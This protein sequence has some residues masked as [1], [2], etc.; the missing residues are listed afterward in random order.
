MWGTPSLRGGTLLVGNR[1]A[2]GSERVRPEHASAA[3]VA[4]VATRSRAGDPASIVLL[5][6]ALA[7]ARDADEAGSRAADLIRE[8]LRVDA[9]VRIAQPDSAGRL[10][11]IWRDGAGGPGAPGSRVA[12]RT[13]Y[14]H[15]VATRVDEPELG[16]R[17]AF[18]PLVWRDRATGVLEVRA[19]IAE[20][21]GRRGVLGAIAAQL[22]GVLAAL[23][24]R[25]ALEREI[26]ALEGFAGLGRQ[27]IRAGRPD[28]AID[29]AVGALWRG[30]RRPVAIWWADEDGART[31]VSV[32]G[33]NATDGADL[34]QRLRRVSPIGVAPTAQERTE[35]GSLFTDAVRRQPEATTVRASDALV[36]LVAGS[37][38]RLQVCLETVGS[39]LDD[40]LPL[41]SA[42]ARGAGAS[43]SLDVGLAWTAHELRTP[44]LGVKAALETVAGR[45]DP[46]NAVLQSSVR[47]LEK[48]AIETERILGWAAGRRPLN[49]T[50]VDVGE[51]V[52]AAV[53]AAGRPDEIAVLVDG[54]AS[55]RAFVDATHLRVAIANLVRNAIRHAGVGVTVAVS[56]EGE[57]FR[58]SVRDRGPGVTSADGDRIF[59]PFVRGHASS[60]AEGA[61]LGLFIA[62]RVVEAHGGRI[63]VEPS[64]EGT[65]VAFHVQLPIDGR[66]LRRPAS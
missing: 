15:R 41:L 40:V 31:F 28:A 5:T 26:E 11:T 13:A 53:A 57:S 64:D 49:R 56:S 39:L 29:R 46:P 16:R 43:S 1:F 9:E 42:S 18:F 52:Q 32:A 17:A 12:R 51:L 63:W 45:V 23:A 24:E 14:A 25:A 19:P 34:I 65:G 59:E 62:R 55:V 35:L 36:A 10:R 27:L 4:E 58:V 6:G 54:E 66:D 2:V 38:P 61:G 20:M 50:Y 33:F 8:S 21:R 60:G 22:A 48:L 30:V 44:I 3:V 37:G 7:S 47:E